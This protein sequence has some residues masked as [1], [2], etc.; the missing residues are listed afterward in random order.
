MLSKDRF[1]D[2]DPRVSDI[3]LSLFELVEQLPIISPHTHIDPAIFADPN[4]HFSNAS[5]LLF[6]SDHYILRM[7][8]SQRYAYDDLISKSDPMGAWQI[9]AD[10]FHL[11]R[12]TA[13]GLW[14]SH[15]LSEVFGIYDILNHNSAVQVYE[16]IN[17]ALQNYEFTPRKLFR[18]FNIE[19]LATT[20]AASSSLNLHQVIRESDWNGRIIPTFRCDNLINLLSL[21]WHQ[22]INTLSEV[23]E[24]NITNYPS[25]IKALLFQREYFKS[26]GATAV[27]I[28]V[29]SIYTKE[30]SDNE[31]TRIFDNALRGCSSHEENTRFIAHML[32]VLAGMSAEDGLVMQLHPFIFRNHNPGVCQQYG[33]DMGFDI[34]I[35]AEF[36]HNLR[37]LLSK[38]GTHANFN[39]ILF[40]LDE[41]AYARELAPLA[42]VYPAIKLGPPWWFNDTWNGIRRYLDQVIETAGIYNIV[43]F[44][45]DARSLVTIPAKH[46]LWRRAV[47][48]WTASLLVRGFI[49]R[50]DAET[51]VSQLAYG[52]A[53]KAYNL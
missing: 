33:P 4:F 10:N 13:T 36:T 31:S 35:R 48:N 5:D 9:F 6:Q 29:E 3:A 21:D 39:L 18:K 50:E 2:S 37:A 32:M 43:G 8:Y 17:A 12:G 14:I 42:G 15:A 23:T 7:L 16:T 46:D 25:F 28:S 53:K 52:L 27:D 24:I 30:L 49:N 1:F 26:L 19:A 45:D 22:Q 38:F 34:P 40:T 41:S 20:D 11:F 44:N 47:C 51:F